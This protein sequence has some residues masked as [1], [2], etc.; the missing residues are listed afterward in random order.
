MKH[1]LNSTLA[2]VISISLCALFKFDQ[3][4]GIILYFLILIN[5][6][7]GIE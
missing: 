7:I 5:L 2:I 3:S 4:T 1:I 6:R